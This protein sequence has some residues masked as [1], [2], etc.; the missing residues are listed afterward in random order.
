MSVYNEGVEQDARCLL[1]SLWWGSCTSASLFEATKRNAVGKGGNHCPLCWQGIAQF[2]LF[3]R[4]RSCVALLSVTQ[5]RLAQMMAVCRMMR[6][7]MPMDA[8]LCK[9]V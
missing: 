7:W 9:P 2:F 5:E 1:L 8:S 4:L 3:H 6:R